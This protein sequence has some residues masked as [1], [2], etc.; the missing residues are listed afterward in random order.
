[1]KIAVLILGILGSFAVLALGGI[2]LSDYQQHRQAI[3]DLQ[4]TAASWGGAQVISEQM[5]ELE[6]TVRAAY[7]ML[8]LGA[9]SLAASF[10]VFKFSKVSA[11]VLLM[12]V[13]V[14]AILV[15][16]TLIFSFLLLI[17]AMLSFF[18]KNRPRL[19]ES[20]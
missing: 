2:W 11:V 9:L 13:I 17:A 20:I 5:N 12:A 19:L 4:Q 7:A 3:A 14:P 15:P 8:I 10:L 18:V 6:R 16:K 1:M